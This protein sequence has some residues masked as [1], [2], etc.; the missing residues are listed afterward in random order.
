MSDGKWG[1]LSEF[2]YAPIKLANGIK[3]IEMSGESFRNKK[4]NSWWVKTMWSKNMDLCGYGRTQRLSWDLRVQTSLW[5]GE[6]LLVERNQRKSGKMK[7]SLKMDKMEYRR[8]SHGYDEAYFLKIRLIEE[9]NDIFFLSN[10]LDINSSLKM[11][12]PGI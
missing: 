2:I 11:N 6:G 1:Y 10:S 8:W 5:K 3:E 4:T 9:Y 12:K 7:H